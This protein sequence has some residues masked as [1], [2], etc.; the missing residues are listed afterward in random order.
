M[1][2]QTAEQVRKLFELYPAVK[3]VYLFGSKARRADGPLS[4][5]DFAIYVEETDRQKMFDLKLELLNRLSRLLGTDRIDVIILNLTASPELKYE[6]IREGE[7]LFEREPFRLLV[8]P[9]ILNEYFDF[10]AQLAR[11]HLTRASSSSP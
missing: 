11:Y 4:D 3:L 2:P 1:D 7:L 5:Y 6:V 8:E 10:H 9:R